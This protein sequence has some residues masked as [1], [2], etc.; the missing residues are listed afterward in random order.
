[1]AQETVQTN[2]LTQPGPGQVPDNTTAVAEE[3]AN[4]ALGEALLFSFRI[5]KIL[6]LF[7]I[8]FYLGSGII[9]VKPDEV[10]VIQRFGKVV[11]HGPEAGAELKPG[12]HWSW[13]WPIDRVIRVQKGKVRTMPAAYWY[14]ESELE[15]VQGQSARAGASLVPGMD[16]YILS[17]D[18]NIFHLKLIVNYVIVDAYNYLR[19]FEKSELWDPNTNPD[20]RPE[21]DLIR[22]MTDSAVLRSAGQFTIDDLLGAQ[23]TRFIILVK[24]NLRESLRSV[25]AGLD[26]QDVLIEQINPP[27]QVVDS[28]NAVRGA[29]EKQQAD[30][31]T[32][33]GDAAKL[34]AQTAGSGYQDL[35]RAMQKVTDLQKSGDAKLPAA[36]EDLRR[37]LDQAGGSVQEILAEAK[38]YKNRV[39]KSAKADSEYLQAL[40]PKYKENPQV[41][42]TRLLL[43]M[44]ETTL[45]KVQKWYIPSG[46][47][48][49]RFSIDRDPAELEQNQPPQQGAQ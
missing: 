38:V 46:V 23:K 14:K 49:I 42:L 16:D 39:V 18:A 1:M 9:Q 37:Q 36:R 45:D 2:D 24:Q 47:R 17:G 40:L 27:R 31:D 44:L 3:T 28:F 5:L 10:A 48:E 30:I 32:A 34:M 35:V 4:Q 13:P 11:V 6:M 41:V 43:G 7:A 15:K 26:I 20:I 8:L 22:A 12:A 25:E 19:T 33:R 29:Y 21:L